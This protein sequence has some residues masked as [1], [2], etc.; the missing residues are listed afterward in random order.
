MT[1]RATGKSLECPK[2]NYEQMKTKLF[3]RKIVCLTYILVNYI[4]K[5]VFTFFC[6]FLFLRYIGMVCT[7]Y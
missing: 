3:F 2:I 1:L 7:F 4:M 5:Y 6:I